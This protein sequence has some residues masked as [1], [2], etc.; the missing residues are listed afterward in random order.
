MKIGILEDST[1]DRQ[2]IENALTSY[3]LK[4]KIP[5]S[6]FFLYFFDNTLTLVDEAD[7]M[8]IIF[9]DVLLRCGVSGMDG[10]R[11]I[12]EKGL[13]VPIIFLTLSRDHAVESYDVNASA[14][15][16]K[17]LHEEK[18]GDVLDRVLSHHTPKELRVISNRAKV[19][20][21]YRDIMYA[22]SSGRTVSIYKKDGAVVKVIIRLDDIEMKMHDT[23]FLRS[24]KSYLVNMDEIESLDGTFFVLHSGIRVPIR[25]REAA[26][27][28]R[29][30]F[31]YLLSQKTDKT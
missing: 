17:P 27:I 8:D 25:Q 1:P 6:D 26:A 18:L 24:H 29:K 14:Y 15:L 20:V 23:R 9:L 28:R 19:S 31:D 7:D 4:R 3:F 10:A 13:S 16:L 22:E 30:F 21:S 2:R 11:K 12:R 5:P